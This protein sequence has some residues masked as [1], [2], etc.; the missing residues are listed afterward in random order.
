MIS[1]MPDTVP[2][3]QGDTEMPT[4]RGEYRFTVKEYASGAPFVAAEP[5]GTFEGLEGFGGDLGFDLQPNTTYEQA[6]DIAKYLNRHIAAITL[7]Y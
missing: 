6:Q 7:T 1:I 5:A 4:E 3:G 2:V